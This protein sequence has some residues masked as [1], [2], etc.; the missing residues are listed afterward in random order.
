M[1]RV[2]EDEI[3]FYKSPKITN[4]KAIIF[5]SS[6]I[7]GGLDILFGILMVYLFNIIIGCVF[8]LIA[9]PII[10]SISIMDERKTSFFLLTNKRLH[11]YQLQK[12]PKDSINIESYPLNSFKGIIFRKRFFDKN[13]DSGT[14]EFIT[15]E[16]IPNKIS[17]KNVP[18]IPKLQNIIE[19]IYF[20]FGN[21]QE[22]CEELSNK[23]EYQF[24]Q[25]YEISVVKLEDLKKSKLI[26]ILILVITPIIT[27]LINYIIS[28]STDLFFITILVFSGGVAYFLIILIP[29][30]IMISRTSDRN[31][32]LVISENKFELYK[33]KTS[34][35]ILINKT[36]SINILR[37]KNPLG[38]RR[39]ILD[40]YDFIKIQ[41]S[42][43]SKERIK[44]GPFSELPYILNFLFCYLLNWKSNHG[45][46]MS[47]DE[48]T[49]L[50]TN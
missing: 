25:N 40:N 7:T 26:Y 19:S 34:L 27:Y 35:T 21:I 41:K 29:I 1:R 50:K 43:K 20:H 11:I 22:K 48:I 32:R 36:T 17:I 6:L 2:D 42:Y 46:L 3:I 37:C 12:S 45:Y 33:S 18:H 38:G 49:Q 8:I 16:I 23:I 39:T 24:P 9:T 10:I 15:D 4:N 31:N 44:F 47:K 13:F 14:I 30:F 28:L 5:F